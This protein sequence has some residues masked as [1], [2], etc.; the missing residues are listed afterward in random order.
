MANIYKE[1]DVFIAQAK[2]EVD[3]KSPELAEARGVM[4]DLSAKFIETKDKGIRTELAEITTTVTNQI[5]RGKTN[6]LETFADVART[7]INVKQQF[8]IEVDLTSAE[9]TAKGVA[10]DRGTL[11]KKYVGMDTKHITT[12]PSISFMDMASGRINF[13]RIALLSA[14]K[15][16]QALTKEMETVLFSAFS[17]MASP[18][19]ETAVGI[20][21]TLLKNQINTF[22]TF[23]QP[24]LL[25][26]I[27]KLTLLDNIA[28]WNGKLPEALALEHNAN[29]FIGT[30][31][32]A[33]V[34]RL[35][36][37]LLRGS[38]TNTQLRKDLMYILSGGDASQ[39]SLKAQFEGQV[40]MRE[41][42][43]FYTGDYDLMMG[44]IAGF[45]VVGAEHY[46]GVYRAQ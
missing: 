39:R 46:M 3:S 6:Y 32:T 27:S 4:K 8:E 44:M 1:V 42:E 18:N 22:G 31:N 13:D 23:G 12:R 17:V 26:D 45:K 7:G 24:Y 9:W 11:T 37:P 21:Q 33:N 36:N 28:G 41:Q 20:D 15:I 30:F 10:G 5:V 2:G 19:Y 29:G 34:V 40:Y 38:L 16:D 14:E 25:G 35:V 43:D